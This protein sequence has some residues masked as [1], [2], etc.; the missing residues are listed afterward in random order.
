MPP[1]DT[2]PPIA[3]EEEA[4]PACQMWKRQLDGLS[5]PQQMPVGGTTARNSA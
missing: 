2:Q 5:G 1:A 4:Q 3:L